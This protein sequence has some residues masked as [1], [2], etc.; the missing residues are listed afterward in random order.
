VTKSILVVSL[1]ALLFGGGAPSLVWEED[2]HLIVNRAAAQRLPADM[3]AF[4]RAA[5]DRLAW[6]GPEPDRWREESE[7]ALKAA[8]EPD[9]YLKFELLGEDFEFPPDRYAFYAALEDLRDQRE[10]AGED[11]DALLP[12]R[13]GLQ[14]YVTVELYDRL[15]VAFRQYRTLIA[16]GEPTELVDG[17][18][19][20]YAGWLGHYVA[21]GA[22]PQH[23][24]V[25]YDGWSGPNP[26]GYSGP[27]LHYRFEGQFVH[28]NITVEDIVPRV[29]PPTRL[30][31]PYNDYLAFLRSSHELV[32]DVFRID[33]GG[34]FTGP[35]TPEGLE[36]AKTRLAA[37]AQMLLDLWYTAWLESAEN[38]E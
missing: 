8:Q 35:G 18:I 36:F 9:H 26:N 2:G 6:L 29:A 15:V 13:V 28:D 4:F 3:P 11:P 38:P 10:A 7:P 1:G 22:Q 17:N 16:D 34:G 19:V 20:L 37:G 23:T 5:E 14:L 25:Q 27:G 12:E 30:D 21:D 24:S 32:E 33:R 31:D